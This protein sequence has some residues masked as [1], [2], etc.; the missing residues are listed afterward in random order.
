MPPNFSPGRPSP[1]AVLTKVSSISPGAARDLE[2]SA[3]ST[4]DVDGHVRCE[5]FW[6][7]GGAR[8]GRVDQ[9]GLRSKSQLGTSCRD[10]RLVWQRNK[11]YIGA[12]LPDSQNAQTPLHASHV[13]GL[14]YYIFKL[15]I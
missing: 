7:A 5:N 11:K 3:S 9:G 15:Y 4:T 12:E 10:D 1:R 8:F 2:V 14:L 6:S 13:A